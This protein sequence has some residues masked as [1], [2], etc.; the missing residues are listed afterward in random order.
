MD[1]ALRNRLWN[2]VRTNCFAPSR[3]PELS[4]NTTLAQLCRDMWDAYFKEP[5]DTIPYYAHDAQK[6]LRARFFACDWWEVYEFVEFVVNDRAFDYIRNELVA[7]FDLVLKEELS[8][9]RFI[10]GRLVP[11]TAKEEVEAVEHAINDT[12]AAFPAASEHLRTAIELLARKPMP[13]YRNSIKESISAVE[14]LCMAV[15]EK[16]K[17]PLGEALKVI[18]SK[19]E[20][21]GALRAA[22]DKL[23]GYTSDAQGI[24]HALLEEDNLEQEDATF[25]LVACSAFV[26]YVIAKLARKQ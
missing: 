14:S 4:L 19:A 1:D 22:F 12:A 25:M 13:D 17:A 16:P 9:Y 3:F 5:L 18:G 24:R 2:I 7:K 15:T 8:G 10:A 20:L 6:N 23:Y 21:H 26:S 11:V